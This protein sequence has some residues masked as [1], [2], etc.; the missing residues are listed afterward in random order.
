MK[1]INE[2]MK[3]IDEISKIPFKLKNELGDIYISPSFNNMEL[4]VEN[5]IRVKNE[6][7]TLVINEK[8]KN[9]IPLLTFCIS[10]A[11]KEQ[12]KREKYIIEDILKGKEISKEEICAVYPFLNEKFSM[13]VVSSEKNLEEA[14]SLIKEGY[15]TQD[16]IVLIYQEKIVILGVLD[17]IKDHAISIKETISSNLFC[18]SI[19]IYTSIANYKKIRDGFI[20]CISKLL[21]ANKFR[22]EEDILGDRDIIFEEIVDSIDISKKEELV[23]QFNKGFKKIDA[24]MMRTI[25]VF[26]KSGLNLSEASK[27]LF[28]HRNTLIYRIEKIEKYTGFDIKNFNQAVIFK[29]VFTLWKEKNKIN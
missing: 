20:K 10:N 18:K 1:K 28:I 8:N 19:I 6:E 29:M 3:D 23:S 22:L 4:N 12:N 7:L 24:E 16:N 9:V 27:E 11:L 2:L 26:L 15:S 25:D 5:V 14:Y 13:I 17:D 21:V